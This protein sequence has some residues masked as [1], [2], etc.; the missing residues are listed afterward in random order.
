MK[1][2]VVALSVLCALLLAVLPAATAS[3]GPQDREDVVQYDAAVLAELLGSYSESHPFPARLT[4]KIA[5]KRFDF[6]VNKKSTIV[7][8]KRTHGGRDAR[9]CVVHDNGGWAT[10]NTRTRDLKSSGRGHACRF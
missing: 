4:N 10:W 7:R 1:K 5:K 6:E 2:T 8:Y 3:A 9:L